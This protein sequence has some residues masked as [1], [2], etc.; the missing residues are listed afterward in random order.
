[1]EQDLILI[2]ETLERERDEGLKTKGMP[3]KTEMSEDEREAGL[4]L[5]RDPALFDRIAGDMSALGYVGEELNKQLLY[6]CASS[7]KLENPISV[8]I[9]SQSASGKS[10]LVDTV[11]KMMPPEEVVAVTSLSDQALNYI[12]GL[13]HK[14]LVL[15]EAVHSEIIEHQIREMLSGKELSRLVTVKDPETGAMQ[16]RIVKTPVIVS[17]VMGST[18]HRINPENASRCF[19]VNADESREQTK[20]IQAKQ[21]EKYSLETLRKGGEEK[22]RIIGAHRAAQRLLKALPVVNDF[23]PHLDFPASLMRTRRD[24]DRFLDLI[25]GVCFLRQYQKKTEKENG[26]EFIRCDPEDYRIAYRIMVSGVL[27]S[28]IC[29]LP[30]GVQHLYEQMREFAR[31]EAASQG[32]DVTLVSMTQRQLREKTGLAQTWVKENIRLLLDYE[33]IT[34][35]QGGGER[36]KGFYRLKSDAPLHRADISMIPSPER[37]LSLY[38]KK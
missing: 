23:A 7:R 4:E 27:S 6:I 36:S 3:E 11:K 28:T 10:F 1:V 14:F 35:M 31:E 8:M 5:L 21:Q 19:I 32:T 30:A 15:G 22:A 9:V 17:S 37:M 13:M 29:E 18:K 20:R 16:S 33:Y 12:D 2:L 26:T 34:R 25:A 24:N 38:E